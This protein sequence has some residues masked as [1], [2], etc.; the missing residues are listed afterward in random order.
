MRESL[1]KEAH[2]DW[3]EGTSLEES[4]SLAGTPSIARRRCPDKL[5]EYLT[6]NEGLFLRYVCGNCLFWVKFA[7]FVQKRGGIVVA[8]PERRRYSRA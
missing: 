4:V 1:T 3:F 8:V 7:D 2:R 5:G 6:T